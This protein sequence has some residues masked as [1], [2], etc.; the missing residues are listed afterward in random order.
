MT[1]LIMVLVVI[2]QF[3]KSAVKL[4]QSVWLWMV[5]GACAYLVPAY[6]L[7]FFT[8]SSVLTAFETA[9]QTSYYMYASILTVIISMVIAFFVR[10]GLESTVQST[11]NGSD[12]LDGK[13]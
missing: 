6:L 9:W 5:I 11:P 12:T 2:R 1:E 7:A 13:I 3:Y 8:V 4:N 10:K